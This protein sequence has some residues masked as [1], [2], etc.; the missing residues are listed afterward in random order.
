MLNISACIITN[1]NHSVLNAI[2]SVYT[3]VN[4]IIL[5]NTVPEFTMDISKY[6]KVKLY[7]F[8]WCDDFS[9]ARNYS[10]S[11]ATG[12]WIFCIDSDEVL[13][14]SFDSVKDDHDFYFLQIENNK[15][16]YDSIRIFK[17]H[18]GIK[19]A[20]RLHESVEDSVLELG[21]KGAKSE[22][23]LGHTG[24]QLDDKG[25][26]EKWKRN[27]R[28]LLKDKKN[29]GRNI[30][31]A[32]HFN[33]LKDFKKAI[34]YA[35]KAL[36]QN[37]INDEN[38]AIL[39]IMIYEGYKNMGMKEA[40]IDYL[41]LSIQFLP[42]QISARYLLVNYLYQLSNKKHFKEAI[43]KQIIAIGS[44]ITFRNS[45]LPNEVYCDINYVNNIRKEIEKWQ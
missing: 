21:L 29:P 36:K 23:I 16:L 11:K 43:L 33:Y 19:Y 4:E 37:N 41:R 6:D 44:L 2:E 35:H 24:Y 39:C 40:G 34:Y 12:D 20:N 9:K 38:K 14:T 25:M 22:V 42:M 28:I 13:K 1:N 7:N 15:T 31:M 3:S 27:Y 32:K 5:V 30:H 10:I 18:I 26:E 8:K 17:N 45:E